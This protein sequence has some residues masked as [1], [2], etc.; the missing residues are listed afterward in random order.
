MIPAE[1]VVPVFTVRRKQT[2]QIMGGKKTFPNE[3]VSNESNEPGSQAEL[4][5]IFLHFSEV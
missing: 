3:N 1:T 4:N 5:Y 2:K